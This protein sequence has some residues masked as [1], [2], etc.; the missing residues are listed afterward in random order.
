MRIAML[1]LGFMGGVHLRALREVPGATLAAV[2]SN[3]ERQLTR[4]SDRH[5]GQSGRPAERLDFTG[6]KLYR[7]LAGV[8]AMPISMPWI[9]ACQ[10]FST[11]RWRWRHC[12]P[13]STS[14]WRSRWPW[15]VFRR[16][17]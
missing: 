9:S 17:V 3:D 12:R 5:A 4:R 13:E 6:I 11:K 16:G 15:M 7:D 1:G 8:W 2:F 10:R 14:W